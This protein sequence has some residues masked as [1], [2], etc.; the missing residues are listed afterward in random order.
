M[1]NLKRRGAKMLS[2]FLILLFLIL[3]VTVGCD[4]FLKSRLPLKYTDIVE[5]YSNE[6]GLDKYLIYA[7]ISTESDFK[8]TAKS[9]AGAMGLMQLMPETAV[10]IGNKISLSV[11]LDSLFDPDTNIHLGCAYLSYLFSRF[12]GDIKK[13]ICAYNGGEGNVRE[14]ASKYSDSLDY[15]PFKETRKYLKKVT[16]RYEIYTEI[17]S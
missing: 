5:K 17:Y 10:W 11:E 16:V 15:I 12:D 13:V 4:T 14:W 3:S 8:P 1:A 7:V 9:D 6:Y 2:Y